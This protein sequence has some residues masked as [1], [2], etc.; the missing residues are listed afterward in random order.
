MTSIAGISAR[1]PDVLGAGLGLK[2]AT[3]IEMEA[4]LK[5]ARANTGSYT[6]I[7]AMLGRHDHSPALTRLTATLAQ[8]V[9]KGRK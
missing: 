8:R 9:E 1:I 4:A 3:E 2:A 7:Q 5:Q 6:I